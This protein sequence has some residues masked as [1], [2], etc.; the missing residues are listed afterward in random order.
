MGGD[1][2]VAVAGDGDPYVADVPVRLTRERIL[3]AAARLFYQRGIRAVN[4]DTVAQ[5]ASLTKVTLYKYFRSKDSLVASCLH[6]LDDR[7]FGW[8]VHEV[9]GRSQDRDC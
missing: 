4:V 6:M 1:G 5:E 8:F 3:E 9:E 7:F 2:S